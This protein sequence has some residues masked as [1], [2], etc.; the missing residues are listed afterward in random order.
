MCKW[1]VK[2]T[3]TWITFNLLSDNRLPASETQPHSWINSLNY[4]DDIWSSAFPF[5]FLFLFLKAN[6]IY[7]VFL[8]RGMFV[9]ISR[10]KINNLHK[11]MNG[12]GKTSVLRNAELLKHAAKQDYLYHARC[13]K[14]RLQI[15]SSL[16][17]ISST[18]FH[19]QG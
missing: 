13:R 11:M 17:K 6:Y 8:S 16:P 2:T 1:A 15:Q 9:L 14:W 5:S 4:Q 12:I 18:C 10:Q 19:F 7:K 3:A